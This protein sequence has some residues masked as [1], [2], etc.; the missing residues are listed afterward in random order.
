MPE[1]VASFRCDDDHLGQRLS[2]YRKRKKP[3]KLLSGF[4]A[5]AQ[6]GENDFILLIPVANI[7]GNR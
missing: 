6:K 3:M 7:V 2:T 5:D 1:L 4:L